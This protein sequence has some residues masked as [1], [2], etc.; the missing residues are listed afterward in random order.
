MSRHR[1]TQRLKLKVL[2]PAGPGIQICINVKPAAK[3]RSSP[4]PVGEGTGAINPIDFPAAAGG[5]P[6]TDTNQLYL[7]RKENVVSRAT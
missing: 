5:V 6:V 3:D 2:P 4:A 1:A 7:L